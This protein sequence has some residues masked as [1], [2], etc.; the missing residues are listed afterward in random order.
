MGMGLNHY[1]DTAQL[2]VTFLE[3][4]KY[5]EGEVNI[6]KEYYDE[7]TSKANKVNV[8]ICAPNTK[9]RDY[10]FDIDEFI[11]VCDAK[12][13]NDC[14]FYIVSL[15]KKDVLVSDKA[16][17][18]IHGRY[19]KLNVKGDFRSL[20]ITRDEYIRISF[21]DYITIFINDIGVGSTS[22]TIAVKQFLSKCTKIDESN[23]FSEYDYGYV[24]SARLTQYDNEFLQL[25]V[26]DEHDL[27][28]Q[29]KSLYV[30]ASSIESAMQLD[31]C[32]KVW[33]LNGNEEAECVCVA[34]QADEIFRHKM[35]A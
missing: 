30:R 19:A 11:D 34:E 16:R 20:R 28:K 9:A 12:T 22:T 24:D 14:E 26:V 35:Y 17:L 4:Q 5:N 27:T 31:F 1:G 33:L 21:C 18:Q 3:D 15:G 6:S 32:T 29:P 10:L 7:I 13:E 2:Y 25:H 8:I 23:M